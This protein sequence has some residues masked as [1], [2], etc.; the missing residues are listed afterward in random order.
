MFHALTGQWH[1]ELRSLPHEQDLLS[2]TVH[3]HRANF[4][5]WHLEDEARD[6]RSSPAEIASLKRDIDRVNQRRNDLVEHIDTSLLASLAEH[7]LPV[8]IAPLHSETPGM[9]LDRLSILSL[10]LF[11][12]EEELRRPGSTP[13]L[14][15]RNGARLGT[16]EMQHGDLAACLRILWQET[17]AGT[18]RFKQYRQLKMYNDPDLNPVLYRD[19]AR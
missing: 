15:Q 8:S 3:L 11:H 18:R 14:Q 5:L 16:L 13:D 12:T 1:G 2:L 6:L 19:A 17:L 7:G 9:M 4:D 10:K